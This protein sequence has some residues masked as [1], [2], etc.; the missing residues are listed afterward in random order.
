M[1]KDLLYQIALTLI[2]NIGDI[3]GK[4]LINHFG[5]AASVFKAKKRELE[6][7]DGIGAVRARSIKEFSNFAPAE[8]EI[9]FIEKFK[10][11]PLFI[12]DTNYPRRLLNCYD[13]PVLLYYRG[14]ADLN[15]AKIIA[16][17]GT[18]NNNEYG[19]GV[20]ENFIEELASQNILIVSGL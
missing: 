17:V 16:V 12:T 9:I 8:E 3:H 4:T 18:R 2:P 7:I 1:H 14:N 6:G 19:K 20:C 11:I 5:D 15:T 13:N 10:I